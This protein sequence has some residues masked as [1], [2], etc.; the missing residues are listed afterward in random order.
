M[1]Y[2]V[3]L[4]LFITILFSCESENEEELFSQPPSDIEVPKDTTSGTTVSFATD[5]QPLIKSNCATPGCHIANNL[6]PT[7]ETYTQIESSR[8]RIKARAVDQG[9]MPQS[10]PLPQIEKD[11]IAT[12]I[13]EGARN[14]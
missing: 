4:L 6:F 13:T 5:I 14:N 11:K 2:S 7:L 8:G 10:G 9:T 1:K 3:L 12:W